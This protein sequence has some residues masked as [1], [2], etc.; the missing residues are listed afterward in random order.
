MRHLLLPVAEHS[1]IIF[2]TPPLVNSFNTLKVA[3]L[4]FCPGQ[5]HSIWRT[6]SWPA[7]P[8]NNRNCP[9]YRAFGLVPH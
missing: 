3:R 5:A 2:E 7:S 8:P 6:M 4:C 1:N 9:K